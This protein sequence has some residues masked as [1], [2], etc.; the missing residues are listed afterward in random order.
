MAAGTGSRRLVAGDAID[1]LRE[2]EEGAGDARMIASAA[3]VEQ[4]GMPAT[5]WAWRA[6]AATGSAAGLRVTTDIGN[7]APAP[8]AEH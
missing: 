4:S 5:R 2:M 6:L 7:P 3:V 8:N 1:A